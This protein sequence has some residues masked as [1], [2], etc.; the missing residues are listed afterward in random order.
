M[1]ARSL[2][3]SELVFGPLGLCRKTEGNCKWE[4]GRA[5]RARLELGHGLCQTTSVVKVS[6]GAW[7]PKRTRD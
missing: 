5:K 1:A 7:L 2:R 4:R 6:Q 3:A